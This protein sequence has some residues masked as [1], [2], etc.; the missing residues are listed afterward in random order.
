M[1][2]IERTSC[3][4]SVVHYLLL[5]KR[6]NSFT[7]LHIVNWCWLRTTW[8]KTCWIVIVSKPSIRAFGKLFWCN[9]YTFQRERETKTRQQN[10]A[11]KQKLLA[12]R[13]CDKYITIAVHLVIFRIEINHFDKILHESSTELYRNGEMKTYI[14]LML[15]KHFELKW[16]LVKQYICHVGYAV[17]WKLYFKFSGERWIFR[18]EQFSHDLWYNIISGG[19]H[20]HFQFGY[21]FPS[22]F[23]LV[24]NILYGISIRMVSAFW[25]AN[26]YH[27]TRFT[28]SNRWSLRT[29]RW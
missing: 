7:C 17:Y 21:K 20:Q 26:I 25:N 29:F 23:F 28:P 14:L 5:T 11:N 3:K 18:G 13:F 24:G 12:M 1:P 15:G 2:H 27:F 19:K 10:Y 16:V 8:K 4:N 9:K 22:N 6:M